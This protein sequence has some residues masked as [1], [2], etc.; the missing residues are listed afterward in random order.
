MKTDFYNDEWEAFVV[1]CG[2]TDDELNVVEFLRRG[3]AGIDI[4]A[5]LTISLSTLTR[6][7]KRITN[8]IKRY[9]SKN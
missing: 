5:E 8:K 9:L 3:W 7:K 4:A 6:R 1:Y 2:F